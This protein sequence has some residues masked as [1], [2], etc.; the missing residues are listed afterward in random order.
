MLRAMK[1]LVK[2]ENIENKVLQLCYRFALNGLMSKIS[3]TV[4]HVSCLLKESKSLLLQSS[5]RQKIIR[6]GNDLLFFSDRI[7]PSNISDIKIISLL[8][9]LRKYKYSSERFLLYQKGTCCNLSLCKRLSHC[10]MLPMK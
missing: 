5:V 10:L 2:V 8:Y 9:Y 6:C 1:F 3:N 7:F 4:N